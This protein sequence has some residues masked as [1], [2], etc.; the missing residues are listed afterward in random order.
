MP[1]SVLSFEFLDRRRARPGQPSQRPRRPE[2][3]GIKDDDYVYYVG[4]RVY[5]C[6]VS[7]CICSKVNHANEREEPENE[8]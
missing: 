7:V 2:E 1:S 6:A 3:T 4:E 5:E 8:L